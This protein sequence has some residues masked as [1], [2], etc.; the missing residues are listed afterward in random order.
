VP[1]PQISTPT[2]IIKINQVR[3]KFS[4]ETQERL[5]SVFTGSATQDDEM[6]V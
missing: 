1:S 6:S 4:Q 3:S 2:P 5:R